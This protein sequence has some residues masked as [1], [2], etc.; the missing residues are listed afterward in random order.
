MDKCKLCKN[1]N[2]TQT[3]SHIFTLSLIKSA[4]NEVGEK[5][6]GKELTF[7][8]SSYEFFSLYFGQ[9]IQPEKI[10]EVIGKEI[11]EE[12]IDQNIN[13]F[14]IDY[15]VCTNCEKRFTTV[16]N[17]FYNHIQLYLNKPETVLPDNRKYGKHMK[18]DEDASLLTRLYFYI[19]IWRASA[20][21]YEDFS[22]DNPTEE[23]L[24]KI[25]DRTLTLDLQSTIVACKHNQKAITQFPLVISHAQTIYDEDNKIKL[26]ENVVYI[27]PHE[28]PNFL[29]LNDFFIQFYIQK[30]HVQ[31]SKK[32]FYGLTDILNGKDIINFE[33]R[34]LIVSQL[35]DTERLKIIRN[36]YHQLSNMVIRNYTRDFIHDFYN[37]YGYLPSDKVILS[38]I[39][40][41]ISKHK[42]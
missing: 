26:T 3:G 36:L 34:E 23:K 31:S 20:A 27:D 9:K 18:L 13:P 7:G 2:A 39:N 19:Q 38:A 32:F 1:N 10:E 21:K 42:A 35:S 25:I 14:T 5:A 12:D 11:E 17:Y 4:I 22:L 29:I 6:R 30:K 37:T 8:I 15:L 24:R 41:L 33:E 16:E 40:L 28:R